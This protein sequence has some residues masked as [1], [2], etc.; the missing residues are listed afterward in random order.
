M[1][2][3]RT[4]RAESVGAAA[5]RRAGSAAAA[6]R[7]HRW[8]A[9]R[10]CPRRTGHTAPA[11]ASARCNCQRPSDEEHG[12][13]HNGEERR[14]RARLE[15]TGA[16]PNAH[17]ILGDPYAAGVEGVDFKYLIILMLVLIIG[18]LGKALYHLSQL[19]AEDEK[20]RKM[21]RALTWRIGLSVGLFAADGRVLPRLDTPASR[22][23][24]ARYSQ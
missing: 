9:W 12:D 6:G 17:D 3:I 19:E 16:D 11:S 23:L 20:S 7:A 4:C 2:S 24:T 21:V 5:P 18:S 22:A 13:Q 1:L 15:D 14:E 10:P 8:A